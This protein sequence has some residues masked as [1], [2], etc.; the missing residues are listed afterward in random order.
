MMTSTS[1]SSMSN[2]TG[3]RGKG[4]ASTPLGKR[5]STSG[6]NMH[7]EKKKREFSPLIDDADEMAEE[8][9]REDDKDTDYVPVTDTAA[10]NDNFKEGDSGEMAAIVNMHRRAFMERAFPPD[11]EFNNQHKAAASINS[12]RPQK[13][14]DYIEYVVK[15]WQHG[16]ELKDMLPSLEKDKLT[17]FRRLHKKGNK[18]C[19]QYFLEEISIPGNDDI[20]FVVRRRETGKNKGKDRIVLSREKVFDAIDDWHRGNGHMGQERTWKF[21]RDKYWNVTE[22]C[23]RIYS[24]TCLVCMKKNPPTKNVK[25]SIKPIQSWQF[26]DRFQIDLIDFRKLRKRDPFGVLMRWV[27]TLKDHATGF[28]YLCALPRK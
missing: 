22:K 19:H 11:A 9:E 24:E 21:C 25:G 2:S 3:G 23:V 16:I 26:R 1:V 7:S 20:Q 28:V 4:A 13:E 12:A 18:Y 17:E 27:M 10:M 5:S 15:H 14:L 6:G 8:S